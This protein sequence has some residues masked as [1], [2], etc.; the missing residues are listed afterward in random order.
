LPCAVLGS[1]CAAVLILNLPPAR[2]FLGDGG[3]HM[4]GYFAAILSLAAAHESSVPV[5][6]VVALLLV[7]VPLF[8]LIFITGTRI[9]KGLPWWRGSSDHFSLRLQAMGYS[10]W[11]AAG[12][13]WLLALLGGLGAVCLPRVGTAIQAVIVTLELV[14]LVAFARWLLIHEGVRA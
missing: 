11:V 9:S 8:E 14:L 4:L 2:I 10:R 3:S 5:R 12:V 6:I 7:F 1:G 13:G